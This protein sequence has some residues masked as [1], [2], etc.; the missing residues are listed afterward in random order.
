MR[1]RRLQLSSR[2]DGSAPV[3]FILV[4]VP[5]VLIFLATLTVAQAAYLR[6]IMT[7]AAVEGSRYAALADGSAAAGVDRSREVLVSALGADFEAEYSAETYFLPSTSGNP[8]EKVV[9]ISIT[10]KLNLAG[11]LPVG[12]IIEA[13]AS[14][15]LE[16]Q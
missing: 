13:V 16:L 5:L 7:D 15:S 2:D 1:C 10:K 9:R 11:L 4:A 14:A 3:D 6:N 8:G 12:P